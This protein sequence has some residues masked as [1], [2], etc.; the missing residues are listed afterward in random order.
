LY[1]LRV[2]GISS[3]FNKNLII[4]KKNKISNHFAIV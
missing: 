4:H 2:Q 3:F 1:T